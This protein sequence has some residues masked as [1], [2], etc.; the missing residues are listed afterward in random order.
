[1]A[2][3]VPKGAPDKSPPLNTRRDFFQQ[4]AS[5][6]GRALRQI[7][8]G[9]LAALFSKNPVG[10]VAQ[11]VLADSILNDHAPPPTPY[12]TWPHLAPEHFVLC[13]GAQGNLWAGGLKVDPILQSGQSISPGGLRIPQI[14]PQSNVTALGPM[15]WKRGDA[16]T[17]LH[18]ENGDLAHLHWDRGQYVL[19][20][21]LNQLL[22][23]KVEVI[24]ETIESKEIVTRTSEILNQGFQSAGVAT[25]WHTYLTLSQND[26]SLVEYNPA[27]EVIYLRDQGSYL[28]V[29]SMVIL[30]R[31]GH[32]VELWLLGSDSQLTVLRSSVLYDGRSPQS[33][34]SAFYQKALPKSMAQYPTARRLI[35]TH[36]GTVKAQV[37]VVLDSG[38]VIFLSSTDTNVVSA[39]Q[40]N[41]PLPLVAPEQ[42]ALT[43]DYQMFDPINDQD[44]WCALWVFRAR[45]AENIV[46]GVA[47]V[48]QEEAQARVL[49][50]SELRQDVIFIAPT[51]TDKALIFANDGPESF[52]SSVCRVQTL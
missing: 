39:Q 49:M 27:S 18:F 31:P 46:L 26:G 3:D 12:E 1:M 43:V 8:T 7:P 36:Q 19:E 24:R 34:S 9:F 45:L 21:R 25:P 29:C 50:L 2:Q 28:S 44:P 11:S 48:K 23:P 30:C 14:I 35:I 5:E 22:T 20:S 4:A 38:S 10:V 42:G 16:L 33:C 51:A 6:A 52:F 32:P 13:L 41:L 17:F 40:I 47:I 37:G 15:T